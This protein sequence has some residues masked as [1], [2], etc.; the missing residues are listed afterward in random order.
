ML[1]FSI[2]VEVKSALNTARKGHRQEFY[3]DF[4]LKDYGPDIC[5]LAF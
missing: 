1:F 2:Y 3:P 4:V 5:I